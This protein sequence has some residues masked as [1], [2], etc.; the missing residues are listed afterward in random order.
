MKFGLKW[1]LWCMGWQINYDWGIHL[2][3]DK[4]FTDWPSYANFH[5]MFHASSYR[6]PY[7]LPGKAACQSHSRSTLMLPHGLLLTG[8]LNVHISFKWYVTAVLR[9]W[10]TILCLVALAVLDLVA[11]SSMFTLSHCRAMLNRIKIA[12]CERKSSYKY[13]VWTCMCA[14]AHFLSQYIGAILQLWWLRSR[15]S[16]EVKS[17]LLIYVCIPYVYSLYNLDNNYWQKC[18]PV[19][20]TRNPNWTPTY[21]TLAVCKHSLHMYIY[22]ELSCLFCT[23]NQR[24]DN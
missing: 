11:C 13:K 16:D 9:N 6:Y 10:W 24:Q 5:K 22:N 1:V 15:W 2:L 14:E 18:M 12:E 4:I 8:K 20:F 21:T 23:V 17:C 19:T 3:M 7:P